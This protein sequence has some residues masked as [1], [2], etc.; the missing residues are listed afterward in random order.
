MSDLNETCFISLGFNCHPKVYIRNVNE[1]TQESLPFDFNFSF[2][3]DTIIYILKSLIEKKEYPM[4]F[5]EINEVIHNSEDLR[6][7]E[8]SGTHIVHF[9]NLN[10][11]KN[12]DNMTYP[13]DIENI[14]PDKI[15]EIKDLFDKR[16]NR[17][18]DILQ[19]EK[20]NNIV[21]I[22]EEFYNSSKNDFDEAKFEELTKLLFELCNINKKLHLIYLNHTI[23]EELCY[24][25]NKNVTTINSINI[26]KYNVN[27][28]PYDITIETN[29][30]NYTSML[31]DVKNFIVDSSNV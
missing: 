3:I 19:G 8:E 11:L 9:F 4:K 2:S 16:Y 28:N 15:I 22:R 10:D 17:F 6:V 14:K 12:N 26:F 25:I 7:I 20:Y 31:Q 29:K 27:P 18:L 23:P 30:V 21:F 24:N 5:I 13:C 1:T